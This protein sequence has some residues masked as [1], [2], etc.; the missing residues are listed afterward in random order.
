MA[1][2]LGFPINSI[3]YAGT[4]GPNDVWAQLQA[5]LGARYTVSGPGDARVTSVSTGT[6]EVT[7]AAGSI[8]GQGILDQIT[9]DVTVQ[10]PTVASGTEWF[11]IVARRTWGLTQA[12]SLT[13]I[14]AG[15]SATIPARNTTPGTIDDQPLA[16][17]PLTAGSTAPG[18]P[19]D[20]RVIG[21][22]KT[23]PAIAFST[24]A[25][26]YYDDP[27]AQVRIGTDVWTRVVL[28]PT[29]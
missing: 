1:N 9:S 15:S 19:I 12:T 2:S 23:G 22:S 25:L 7:V 21:A 27:G 3:G 20:L 13:W 14:D 16:L 24:L 18:T 17:V 6:R 29:Y 11:L 10:L 8:G 4:I 26:S 5:I 28:A